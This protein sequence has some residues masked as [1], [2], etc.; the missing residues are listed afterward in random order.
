MRRI[1]SFIKLNCLGFTLLELTLVIFFMALIAGLTTPFVM[2]TLDRM[3]LQSSARKVASTLRYARSEAISAK[4]PVVFAGNLTQNQFWVNHTHENETPR[5]VSLTGPIRLA[6][7]MNE[8]ANE[9]FSEG[10]FTVTFFP[11]GNSSGGLISMDIKESRESEN[12]YVIS[13]DTITGTTKIKE[14]E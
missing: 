2:S 1:V 5:I 10:E 14:T 12:Y 3:E 9:I 13:I 4:K 11:Q 8:G 6:R 7:F